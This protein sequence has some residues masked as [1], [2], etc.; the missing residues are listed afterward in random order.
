MA[1]LDRPMAAVVA[2]AYRMA[3]FDKVC[4]PPTVMAYGAEAAATE[5]VKA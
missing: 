5:P 4:P 3:D 1:I 2:G